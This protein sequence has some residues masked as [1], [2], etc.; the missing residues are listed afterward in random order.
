MIYKL[1][2]GITL[3]LVL[4]LF[5]AWNLHTTLSM[6]R[7]FNASEADVWRVWND[8]DSIQKWWG[9]KG[10]SARVV[11]ND[12]RKGGSYL[13]AMR[14][15]QGRMFWNTGTYKEVIPGKRIVSTMAFCNENGNTIPGSQVSFPGIGLTRSQ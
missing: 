1:L 14:S 2:G 10:H 12:L 11:R 9:P 5:G 8:A 3:I 15:E 4:L 6:E 13:W 7:T